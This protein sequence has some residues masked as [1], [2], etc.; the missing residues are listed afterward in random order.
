MKKKMMAVLLGIGLMLAA[1]PAAAEELTNVTPGGSTQVEADIVNGD[2]G[3]VS[4]IIAIPEKI[5]FGT[6]QIPEDTSVAHPKKVDFEV[7]AIEINGLDV[8]LQRV[9]V[10]LKDSETGTETFKIT[11]ISG[12]NV[13]EE[14]KE[15]EY[16]VLNAAG[17]DVTSGTMYPN[18][19]GYAAFSAAGQSVN[20]MLSLEQNQILDKDPN[21]K[22]ENWAGDY[23]GTINFY[24]TIVNLTQIMSVE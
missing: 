10:L 5:D 7:S 21:P 15:L 11:Q 22:I 2:S 17:V 16:K 3:E 8:T 19:F 1:I 18:G 20:G 9:A 13:M 23:A 12:S 24:T 4:Y 6:L 14:R